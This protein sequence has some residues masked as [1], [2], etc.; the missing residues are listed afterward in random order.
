[1]LSDE[2]VLDGGERIEDHLMEAADERVRDVAILTFACAPGEGGPVAA[3]VTDLDLCRGGDGALR[4]AS[5]G[6]ADLLSTCCELAFVGG[7]GV[8]LRCFEDEVHA[9]SGLPYKTVY[10]WSVA[11]DLVGMSEATL[12]DVYCTGPDGQ[13]IPPETA[14]RYRPTA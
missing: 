3:L 2:E 5:A 9:P 6:H 1:G 13:P 11:G 4:V 7:G 14:V 8:T 12:F 10:G